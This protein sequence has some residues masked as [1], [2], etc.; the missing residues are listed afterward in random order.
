MPGPFRALWPIP[1]L[2][3]NKNSVS[4]VFRRCTWYVVLGVFP[5]CPEEPPPATWHIVSSTKSQRQG[6]L[7][8]TLQFSWRVD[9]SPVDV[10]YFLSR[11]GLVFSFKASSPESKTPSLSCPVEFGRVRVHS[12]TVPACPMVQGPWK[13]RP[14]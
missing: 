5:Q 13:Y 11:I 10:V 4:E 9:M 14:R 1:L 6:T 3:G 2:Q 12:F 8:G 7:Q